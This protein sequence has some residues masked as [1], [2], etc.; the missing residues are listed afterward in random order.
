MIKDLNENEIKVLTVLFNYTDCWGEH[1]IGFSWIEEETKLT[2]KEISKA[3]K[4]LREKELVHFYTGLIDGDGMFAGS[5]YCIS[6]NGQAVINPCDR[7]E[8]AAFFDWHEDSS[9]EWT[10]MEGPGVVHIRLCSEHHKE[11]KNARP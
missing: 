7:C 6:D 8:K 4:V 2:K 9:G 5:G 1:C 11:Y 10:S 3:C